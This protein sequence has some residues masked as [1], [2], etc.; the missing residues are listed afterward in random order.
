MANT[1]PGTAKGAAEPGTAKAA[2]PGTAKAAEPGTAENSEGEV[3]AG[4]DEEA[5]F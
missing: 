4:T 2:E 3:G 5:K 1:E